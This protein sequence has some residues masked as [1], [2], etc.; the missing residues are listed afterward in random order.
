M[1]RHILLATDLLE[2]SYA[3]EEKLATIKQMTASK[4]SIVHVIE[5]LIT[6]YPVGGGAAFYNFQEIQDTLEENAK[7]RL[8]K[9]KK[10]MNIPDS[11]VNVLTGSTTLE[12]LSY[13][14]ENNVD[15]I[16]TGSHGKHGLNLLLGS[17]ANGILH[18]AKCDVLAV[19]I[20]EANLQSEFYSKALR[21]IYE[22]KLRE[23]L[24]R[25]SK[26]MEHLKFKAGEFKEEV[27]MVYGQHAEHIRSM[28]A[29]A[30]DKL[31]E[32][33][34]ASAGSW[35]SLK[36]GVDNTKDALTESLKNFKNKFH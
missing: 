11:T 34:E 24:D 30:K 8:T 23:Q 12:I 27:K 10:R 33:E 14:K 32:L 36:E 1:Y 20:N 21:D 28:Q 18:G 16:V 6:A 3:I 7:Q 17:T 26:E 9:M 19:R 22:N 13:A 35:E 4:L 29:T 31:D 25:V 2:T 15:L 5:P